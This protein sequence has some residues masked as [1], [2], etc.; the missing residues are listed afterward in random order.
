M[1]SFNGRTFDL[2]VLKYRAMKYRLSAKFLHCSGDRWSNYLNRYSLDWHCDLLEAL[3][4]YGTSARVKMSEVCA[5]LGL[6][7]KI[8]IDGGDVQSMYDNGNIA[9]IGHY[10]E[11]DVLNTYLIYLIHRQH[12]GYLK[13][14]D[15]NEEITNIIEYLQNNAEQYIHLQEFLNSWSVSNNSSFYI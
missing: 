11:T 13:T 5:I 1:V 15:Y 10:C 7:G 3:S 12:Q 4:D 8:G 6:P 9:Q 14:R 2:P